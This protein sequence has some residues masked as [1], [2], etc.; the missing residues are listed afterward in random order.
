VRSHGIKR[1]EARRDFVG[2]MKR[3]MFEVI[4]PEDGQDD[5]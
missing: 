3:K 1:E 2:V 5:K 4:F